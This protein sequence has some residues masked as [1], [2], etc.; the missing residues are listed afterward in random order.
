MAWMGRV[1]VGGIQ[2]S[3]TITERLLNQQRARTTT[4]KQENTHGNAQ[5]Q[6]P[7][8]AQLP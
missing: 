4:S 2:S 1:E 3:T 7:F 6:L 5:R 8:R